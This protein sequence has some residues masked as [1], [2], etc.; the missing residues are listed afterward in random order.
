MPSSSQDKPNGAD[1]IAAMQTAF[2]R[3]AAT[4]AHAVGEC[5]FSVCG[6]SVR[7]RMVGRRLAEE[8]TPPFAHLRCSEPTAKADVTI[9]VWDQVET[10]VS[11]RPAGDNTDET[12]Y[13]LLTPYSEDRYVSD[14]R[15]DKTLWLDRRTR[16]I[17][18]FSGSADVLH[19]DER[20]RPFQR[21]MSIVLSDRGVVPVHSGLVSWRGRGVMFAGMSGSGKSTSSIA[22]LG[23]GF[24]Y[25]GDDFIGIDQSPEGVFT[26]YSIYASCLLTPD[27]LGRFPHLGAGVERAHH[28]HEEKSLVY[29]SRLYPE[30]MKPTVPVSVIAL[31]RVVG[32]GE[33]T[34]RPAS[35]AETLRTLAPSTVLTFVPS[36]ARAH[37]FELLARMVDSVPSYWLELGGDVNHIK[38]AVRRMID[39][40]EAQ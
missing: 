18:G 4:C 35:K 19:T 17:V 24:G 22:C 13:S 27:H 2:D 34:F 40:A 36:A 38:D 11:G 3:A 9:D 28:A 26:G 37:A 7:L 14:E 23:D 8:I 12:F 32:V 1:A 39:A 21:F 30:E 5:N 16:H 10:G 15:R 6:A 31:P 25:L 29:L 20:A 33:T